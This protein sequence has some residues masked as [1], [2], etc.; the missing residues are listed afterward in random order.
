MNLLFD[1]LVADDERPTVDVLAHYLDQDP[2]IRRV[3][4]A[5]SAREA[6]RILYDQPVDAAFLD[7]HMPGL[8]GLELARVI[9]RFAHPPA[10][11]FV[12]ADEDQALK[13]FDLNATDYLLKPVSPERLRQAVGRLG[14]TSSALRAD[15]D[16]ITV[17]SSGVTKM[18]PQASILYVEAS[19]DYVRL[20]TATGDYLVRAPISTLEEQWSQA[21]FVRIHRS[22]LVALKH[23]REFQFGKTTGSVVVGSVQ[24]PVSRRCAAQVR[25]R[26]Q[27]TRISSPALH[28]PAEE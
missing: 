19:G 15:S 4:R 13:A 20:H 25:R 10:I 22:Y 5:V 17:D 21:G 7:I 8:S 24:L 23:V 27:A 11:I 14:G 9:N 1:V 12:T 18:I 2:R 26:L 6:L 16:L 28:R 3:H